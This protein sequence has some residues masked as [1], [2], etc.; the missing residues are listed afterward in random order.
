VPI[1]VLEYEIDMIRRGIEILPTGENH[2]LSLI[3]SG[4]TG[5]IK[6]L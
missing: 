1:N 3:N 4:I 2:L 6:A 5:G